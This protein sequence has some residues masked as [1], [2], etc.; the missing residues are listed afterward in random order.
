MRFCK[1]LWL[2]LLIGLYYK[3]PRASRAL[4]IGASTAWAMWLFTPGDSF[5]SSTALVVLSGLLRQEWAAAAIP[6]TI[7]TLQIVVTFKRFN[8]FRL[9][10][11]FASSSW[12]LFLCISYFISNPLIPA[13]GVYIT[14]TVF[15]LWIVWRDTNP[16][17]SP[18]LTNVQEWP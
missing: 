16:K 3:D 11:D 10:A 17:P 7:S 15:S 18:L 8:R 12:W 6:L 4:L 14:L 5:K 1:R 13:I 2:R 9:V